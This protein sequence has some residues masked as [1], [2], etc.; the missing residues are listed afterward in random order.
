MSKKND[1]ACA[2]AK[3]TSIGGQALME[4]IMMR[5]PKMTAM[6]VRNPK[7]EIVLEKWRTST[8]KVS[9]IKKLPILR[10]VFGFIDSMKTGY[11]SLMRSAEIAGLEDA[12][13]EADAEKEA[14][15]A[16]KKAAKQAK[17]GEPAVEEP[18][19]EETVVEETVVEE[20]VA[21]ETVAEETVTEQTESEKTET[22]SE[23]KAEKK[24]SSALMNGIMIVASVLGVVL[25]LVLFSWLPTELYGHL[26]NWLPFLPLENMALN[27]LLKSAFEGILKIT[28][29]VAYMLAVRL[30]KDIRRTFQYH[31]AEHKTIF[32]YEN[33]LELTVENVRM[34]KRFHPR[35]GTSFLILMLLV[36][37]FVGFFIDPLFVLIFG[38]SVDLNEMKM[39]LLRAA[40]KTLLLPLIMGVGYEL[41]KLAGRQDNWFTRLI[42]AP[43]KWMQRITVM[44][45][46]D[47]MIEC[48]IAAFVEVIP[49]DGSDSLDQPAPEQT[50]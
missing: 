15:K 39:R 14:K 23:K 19:V 31:G 13:N 24:E 49:D 30:M 34:Q 10:G 1:K 36:G 17:N 4:G 26:Q 16:A 9:K 18:I 20:T 8:G 21:E 25:A 48:A 37:I 11:K 2:C 47:D 35:C 44:E 28:I 38:E 33:G 3:K 32:C 22:K 27:S 40:I 41:I 5:G 7:G 45:P 6:A 50:N 12:L 46:T 43:G 42:S 29:L